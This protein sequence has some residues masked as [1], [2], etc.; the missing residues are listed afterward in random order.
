VTGAS[1]FRRQSRLL[2]IT[3]HLSVLAGWEALSRWVVP[4]QFLPPPS[5]IARAC[6]TMTQSGELP[7]Q[8]WHTT[9]VLTLGFGL[10]IVSGA[11]LGIAMGMF[12]TLGRVL[13]PYVNAFSAMPTVALVPL[14]IIWLGLGFEAKVFLTWLV[15]ISPVIINAQIGVRN[16][17]PAFIET[18][19]A[20]GCRRR[21]IFRRVILPAAMPFFV[22]GIRVGLGRALVG[23][24]V[25]EMFTALDG[26][27]YLMVLYG[28]T[29]RTAELFVPIIVL[30]TLSIA[31]TNLIQ[32]IEQRMAPWRVIED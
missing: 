2:P 9:S 19:R 17:P 28:N 3:T 11:A 16:V 1:A 7:Q 18:A 12:S 25:A 10:A 5:A 23:A 6:V 20:F 8:L 30:A 15:S 24:I 21:Q 26:L 32:R 22:A 31:I 13:D 4:P 27:G 29:F 14:V